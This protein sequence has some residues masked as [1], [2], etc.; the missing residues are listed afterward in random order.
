MPLSLFCTSLPSTPDNS[1]CR[2]HSTLTSV[3]L[4]GCGPG[5]IPS[6]NRE[7][8]KGTPC[9]KGM[10]CIMQ[11]FNHYLKVWHLIESDLIFY[12]LSNPTS[13]SALNCIWHTRTAATPPS[14][15][16]SLCCPDAAGPIRKDEG[17]GWVGGELGTIIQKSHLKKILGYSQLSLVVALG[18][19][20]LPT[21]TPGEKQL[22]SRLVLWLKLMGWALCSL[23]EATVA[24]YSPWAEPSQPSPGRAGTKGICL[25]NFV[26]LAMVP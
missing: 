7:F 17:W 8:S 5:G 26:F 11:R 25:W 19:C 23:L 16:P 1:H 24:V 10:S 4:Y 21:H 2:W 14:P 6:V 9:C 20:P 12:P 22:E 18:T 13:L 3:Q 15:S